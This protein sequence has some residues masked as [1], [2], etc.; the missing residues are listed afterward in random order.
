MSSFDNR[1]DAFESKYAHDQEMMFKAEARCCKLLGLWLAGEMGLAGADADAYAKEV[2]AS[3]LDEAGFDDVKRKVLA[4][5]KAKG[6]S[7]S[8]HMIDRQIDK[9]FADAKAQILAGK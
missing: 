7:I 9:C 8:E 2:V 6:L 3:N 1:K 4:D 5:I